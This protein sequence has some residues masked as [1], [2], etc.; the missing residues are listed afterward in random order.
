MRFKIVLCG[1]CAVLIGGLLYLSVQ[2]TDGGTR[3]VSAASAAQNVPALTSQQLALIQA[4][5]TLLLS[6]DEAAETLVLL[7][8]NGDNDLDEAMHDL[9]RRVHVGATNPEVQV[10][11]VLDWPNKDKL[12]PA[13][14]HR[15]VVDR[16]GKTTCDFQVDYTCGGR[17]VPGQNVKDFPEDLGNPANL[18][19]FIVDAMA[20]Y[21]D[22]KRVA[23]ALV[24][25]GGGW[26]PNLLAGQPQ[27]HDGQ[28]GGDDKIGGLLWDDYTGNGPGSSLST[29]DLRQ[30]LSDTVAIT[31]HK[32]D[33][34]YLDACLMG[35]WEVAHEVRNEV[36]YLLASESWTWTAFAYDA[37]LL[38]IRNTQ[39]T[40]EIGQTWLQDKKTQ[41]DQAHYPFTY[42]LLDLTQLP[43]VTTSIDAL[44]QQLTPLAASAA[45]KLKLHSAFTTSAC[46][47]GNADHIINLSNPSAGKLD[48]YCDLQSFTTQ[49]QQQF[50]TLPELVSA[51]QAAQNALA[52]TVVRADNSSNCR[53]PGKYSTIPWCWPKLGGLSIY[54][55]LG[56]DDWKRGLYAQ[57]Q[58][59]TDTHWDEFINQYWDNAAAPA[60]P[61]CPTGGCPLPD[62]PLQIIYTIFL[63]VV[64]R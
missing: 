54:T 41:I 20:E 32:I 9:V 43:T 17:Y 50:A 31:G 13:N 21:P 27:G 37:H 38:G 39:S 44:A 49:L 51:V 7:Y 34:L 45:G 4:I 33:L 53:A 23:L 59:A 8:I 30:A 6:D 52:K 14:S 60:E 63:P 48:N 25:H 40:A 26:S 42:S 19:Q 56:E 29:L 10:V 1:V 55:P 22:A 18:S 47:D 16:R 24:G 11:M 15:Y 35:M 61:T 58:V 64:Q 12:G 3:R 46:F 36:N 57:L 2:L 5:N 28:P 62:G